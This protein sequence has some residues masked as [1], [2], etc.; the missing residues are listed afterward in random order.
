MYTPDHAGFEML[1][2]Q[3]PESSTGDCSYVALKS[4]SGY[5]NYRNDSV[6]AEPMVMECT[7]SHEFIKGRSVSGD[8]ND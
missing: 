7:P 2:P 8:A 6:T 5:A 3:S 4:S 1:H